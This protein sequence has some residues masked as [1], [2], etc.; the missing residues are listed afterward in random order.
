M[1]VFTVPVQN[2]AK[3]QLEALGLKQKMGEVEVDISVKNA[4]FLADLEDCPLSRI[5]GG[6]MAFDCPIDKELL[7]IPWS[8]ILH[9][10]A[11]KC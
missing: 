5:D 3:A 1:K 8:N 11:R 9:F 4:A 10:R 6:G 7:F 2:R